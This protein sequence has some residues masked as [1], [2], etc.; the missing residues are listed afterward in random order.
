MPD[1]ALLALGLGLAVA[2][3]AFAAAALALR[4]WIDVVLA[5]FLLGWTALVLETMA[6]SVVDAWTRTSMVCALALGCAVSVAVWAAR[7]RPSLPARG[8]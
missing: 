5:S 2:T 3:G 7:G 1:L 6:L 4:S 8:R